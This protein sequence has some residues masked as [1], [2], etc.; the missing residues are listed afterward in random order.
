MFSF[1]KSFHKE[2]TNAMEQLTEINE[3]IKKEKSCSLHEFE[4]IHSHGRVQT[5]K[6]SH[7]GCIV[8]NNFVDAYYR[9]LEHGRR[10]GA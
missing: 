9:G 6:C 4:P 3:N 10:N 5:W 1:G 2:Y 8:D 7:C